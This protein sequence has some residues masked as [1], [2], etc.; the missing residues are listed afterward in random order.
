L[1]KAILHMAEVGP[2]ERAEMGRSGRDFYVQQLSS[3]VGG[4]RLSDLLTSAVE[5][6][7]K[8]GTGAP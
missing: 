2:H 6:R 3:R 7:A 1:A 5:E 4:A 8:V